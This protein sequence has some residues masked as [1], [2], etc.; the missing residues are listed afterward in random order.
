M[1]SIIFSCP[2]C[3]ETERV[4]RYGRTKQGSERLYCNV[5]RRAFTP[6]P[7]SR[8]LSA[9]KERL[10]LNALAEKTPMVGIARTFGVSRNT[11]YALLKKVSSL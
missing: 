2:H 6:S 1:F 5:C 3:A 7:K 11:L 9:E 4:R 8:S 10:I